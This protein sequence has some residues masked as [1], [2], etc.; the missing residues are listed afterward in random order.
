MYEKMKK[1]LIAG[2]CCAVLL[3]GQPPAALAGE[4]ADSDQ[5]A[6]TGQNDTL[7]MELDTV[8]ETDT[9]L[10]TESDTAL[11]TEPLLEETG[12]AQGE[13]TDSSSDCAAETEQNNILETEKFQEPMLLDAA[14]PEINVSVK[15]NVITVILTGV[16]TGSD[17]VVFPV[18][19]ESG[20]QDDIQW[21]DGQRVDRTTWKA[22][23]DMK[24]HDFSSGEY[25]FHV[26]RKSAQGNL[27]IIGGA[28]A[29]CNAVLSGSIHIVN[30][31]DDYGT[32]TVEIRD[33]AAP[34]EISNVQVPVWSENQGQ[35]DIR[36]Y[37]AVKKGDVWS[38][39]INAADHFAD[40][41]TYNIHL[42]YS[43][44]KGQLA[45]ADGIKT[46]IHL[47][48]VKNGTLTARS[49]AASGK[50]TVTYT[51]IIA[52]Q[53]SDL[54]FP[55]WTESGG[56]DD[57]VWYTAQKI[58][59][60]T[61]R[62]ET[63]LSAHHYEDG[64]Y[65][66]HAYARDSKGSLSMVGNTVIDIENLIGGEVHIINKDMD[67]GRF[68][69]QIENVK[70]PF[71]FQIMVP[72]W[73]EAN[74]QDDI[75]W[76]SAKKSGNSWEAEVDLADHF[77]ISGTYDMHLYYIDNSGNYYLLQGFSE[78]MK[79]K[80]PDTAR[81]STKLSGDQTEMNIT[82]YPGMDIGNA[83]GVR[84]AVWSEENGQD[85]LT[86]YTADSSAY[87][88]W[89]K[90]I[91]MREQGGGSGTYDIH[92]Y[93]VMADG[94]MEIVLG[95]TAYVTPIAAASGISVT[96]TDE[97]SGQFRVK[98][99]GLSSPAEITNV[100]FP[101]WSDQNGQD[102]IRWYQAYRDGDEWYADV[103]AIDH[104][105][106]SGAYQIHCYAYDAR[107]VEQFVGNAVHNVSIT[108]VSD[109]NI[110]ASVRA[111]SWI[112]YDAGS[113]KILYSRNPDGIVQLASQT[114]IMTAMVVLDHVSDLNAAVTMTASA[115]TGMSWDT[116]KTGL[117]VGRSYTVRTLLEG[118]LVYSGG[119]CANL[120]AEY[121]AGSRSAF[122]ELM[123]QKAV[124]LGMSRTMFSDPVGL[125]DN[126]TTPREYMKLVKY[127]DQN[128]VV[129]DIVKMTSCTIYDTQ[130]MN[131]RR[132]SNS[133]GLISG[134]VAYDRNMYVVDGM[135]TG[136]TESAG[137]CLTATASNSSGRRVIVA[138]FNSTSYLQRALDAKTLL[139][140]G[141][142]AGS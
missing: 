53:N 133:N 110:S 43:G 100:L 117:V 87:N 47:D 122:V 90:T 27:T 28:K 1:R 60:V 38:V 127:A 65:I 131:A 108:P 21:Y 25:N 124:E 109:G 30:K 73:S 13:S 94:S 139:D 14:A 32:F 3:C 16:D 78:E 51:G 59:S 99:S 79:L 93:K 9:I 34:F 72:V 71:D 64:N 11:E 113:G 138:A 126:Y 120:L 2:L 74:G 33:I 85:D 45:F 8:L 20:G 89:T 118:L 96:D 116:T 115:N 97:Q 81:I 18:W 4:T 5:I 88:T 46:D 36:W 35:D 125:Y 128:A 31:N 37:S 70:A 24:N 57:I 17:Q 111:S 129:R 10:E 141:F 86:W 49:D 136:T 95:T 123:N 77:Y 132:L 7:E 68:T 101:V 121:V 39:D 142:A 29:V 50:L 104:N 105:Y 54:L 58:N 91:Y 23:I 92:I 82:L 41:G 61:W 22:E 130:G 75:V 107:G 55:I 44:T 114:K 62:L 98:I 112:I 80:S 40:E 106:D 119:D 134:A 137:Y 6:E 83:V 76:Y 52:D 12:P 15:N 56:Q 42:Y 135:K 48:A 66:I 103:Q 140:Y 84:F 102:D 67:Q 26:Y 69:I 19:T 63:N